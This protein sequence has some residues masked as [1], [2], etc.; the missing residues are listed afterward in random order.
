[1][2]CARRS[3]IAGRFFS[4]SGVFSRLMPR[5]RAKR[6]FSKCIRDV[7]PQADLCPLSY[8]FPENSR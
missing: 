1:M 4:I 5:R 2:P 3:K 7:P 8:V 6:P